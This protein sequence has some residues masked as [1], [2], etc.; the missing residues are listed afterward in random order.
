MSA[1]RFACS[2][3]A[4]SADEEA[5]ALELLRRHGVTGI[6]IAPTRCWPG[7]EGASVAAAKARSQVIADDGFAVA[8]LQAIL[9]GRPGATLF[10]ADGGQAFEHHLRHVALLAEALGARTCVLGAPRNRQRGGLDEGRARERALPLMRRLA[11]AFADAG[12]VLAV[13]PVRPEYGGDFLTSTLDVLDFVR[14]VGHPGMAVQLDAAAL[15]S[16]GETLDGVWQASE[17]GR[18][19]T[20]YHASEPA[21]VGYQATVAPQLDNLHF[22]ARAGWRGWC[23]FE[24]VRQDEGLTQA[25]PW[26]LLGA[27][28]SAE[29]PA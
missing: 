9:F 4:W 24:M 14:E 22:L 27:W 20:H 29:S 6:E 5:G 28:R 10:G 13:E 7:W 23:S 1:L 3:L 2:N 25:G 8:A 16:A 15:H 21:L 11:G 12:T 19:L 18:W 26:A 17:G